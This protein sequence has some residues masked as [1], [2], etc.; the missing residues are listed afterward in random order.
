MEGVVLFLV[1]VVVFVK[2]NTTRFII[3]FT[4]ASY[5]QYIFVIICC[6]HIILIFRKFLSGIPFVYMVLV[7]P[8]GFLVNTDSIGPHYGIHT[9]YAH[10]E[11]TA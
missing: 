9:N 3:G 5:G 7:V 8:I 4:V 11:L 6:L 10:L 1:L 2:H